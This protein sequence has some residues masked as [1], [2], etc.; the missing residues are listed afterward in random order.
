MNTD[1]RKGSISDDSPEI[2]PCMLAN[3]LRSLAMIR[4]LH[5]VL[6]T[7]LFLLLLVAFAFSS[8]IQS[9]RAAGSPL[10]TLRAGEPSPMPLATAD[11]QANSPA[12]SEKAR[13]ALAPL[14][15]NAGGAL[16]TC[17]V[18][19]TAGW[20]ATPFILQ[21]GETVRVQYNYGGWTV[22]ALS[23]PQVGAEGYAPEIDSTIAP[24]C[25]VD[26]G[27]P[28][29]KLLGQI[30]NGPLIPIGGTLNDITANSSGALN[31]RINDQDGCLSDND[32]W[33]I[34]SILYEGGFSCANVTEIPVSECEGLVDL[35]NST[36]G[37][38]WTNRS[39]W[40][41]T[42]TLCSWFG[43]S[44]YNNHLY[45]VNLPNNNLVGTL[46]I[47]INKLGFVDGLYLNDNHL[48]GSI[49][50]PIGQLTLL[51]LD[52]SN[53]QLGGAIPPELGSIAGINHLFLD[54][55]QFTG[56]IPPELG[57]FNRIISLHLSANYLSGPIPTQLGNLT[58]LVNLGLCCN[59]LSGQIPA[60]LGN[61][62][63]L[64]FLA[65]DSNQFTGSLPS[66]LGNL[67]D[68]IE[69]HL[70]N[71]GSVNGPLP[72][73][74]TNL[75]NLANFGFFN[76]GLCEPGDSTFQNWLA[77]IANLQRTNI[78]C[79][80]L[81]VSF[82]APTFRV[83]ENG[84]IEGSH[85]VRLS[86]SSSQPV[87]VQLNTSNGS[88]TTGSD[89]V[90]TSI[91]FTFSP[92]ESSKSFVIP[93]LQDALDEDDEAINLTLSNPTNATLGTPANA[94]LII[95]DD[96]PLPTVQFSAPTYSINES[97]GGATIWAN[98]SP[99]SGRRVTVN[100]AT[101]DGTAI[102]GS[103]YQ[104]KSGTLIFNAG[105][106]SRPF[107]VPILDD[108][109]AEEAESV[110][111]TLSGASSSANLGALTSAILT[112]ADNDQSPC[113]TLATTVSP[114]NA[115][116]I[117]VSPA[118]DCQGGQYTQGTVVSLS[119][120]AS[121][122]FEFGVWSGAAN[123]P[124]NP[125]S[126][127]MLDNKQVTANFNP[128]PNTPPV[129][130]NQSVSTAQG[131]PV[132]IRLTASDAENDP[133]SFVILTGPAHGAFLGTAPSL[134]YQPAPGFSGGDS[135]TFK[136][137]DGKADSNIATVTINVSPRVCYSLTTTVNSGDRGTVAVTPDPNCQG[138]KYTL[139]STVSL[140][141]MATTN[142]SFERWSGSVN[143]SSNPLSIVMD[144]D[145]AVTAT[146]APTT[147]S[148]SNMTEIP[149]SE[150][151]ALVQL[152][153][154]TNGVAW[155]NH[156]G[157]LA[158]LTPCSW[159]GVTCANQHV[160]ALN[161]DDNQLAGSVPAQI[162]NLPYLV[163]LDLNSNQIGGAIPPEITFLA[164][165]Q[166]LD[167]SINYL[168]GAIPSQIGALTSLTHLY[169]GENE[170]TGNAPAQL[171]SLSNLVELG[172][173]TNQL[174]GSI[175]T[176]IGNLTRLTSLS[177][178]DNQFTGKLPDSLANLTNLIYLYLS[179]NEFSG[180]LPANLPNLTKLTTFW[181]Q[182]TH[183][184]EPPNAAFQ[185]WLNS[186][187]FNNRTNIQCVVA[188]FSASPLIEEGSLRDIP[189]L[190]IKVF[191]HS[192]G[193]Y[194][195]C[196]WDFGD[197]TTRDGC[198]LTL[199]I[200]I[201]RE[202]GSYNMSLTASGP[203]GTDTKTRPDYITV[204]KPDEIT[205]RVID[206][207]GAPISG[208]TITMD[209]KTTATTNSDGY[210]TLKGIFAG[211]YTLTPS[212][213]ENTFS[214]ASHTISVTGSSAG[215]DFKINCETSPTTGLNSCKL[216]AG[217]ILLVRGTGEGLFGEATTYLIK[218]GSYFHHAAIYVG[219]QEVTEATGLT[220]YIKKMK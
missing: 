188:D 90:A 37:P 122:G 68:L 89:F 121:P 96:D 175:P 117:N 66:Q 115:G 177:L 136:V 64:K 209:T 194:D 6:P 215:H 101:S 187:Q 143:S 164:R 45:L 107:T 1:S 186:I 30:G 137:N 132:N 29:G 36:N 217:D 157:W 42:L 212:Q 40:L 211:T 184:C 196:I 8:H 114:N 200:H 213:G 102:A 192:M 123:G 145:K 126:I 118:P 82:S 112:I 28:Y 105:D 84:Q 153:I 193:S 160:S 47:Q 133:L 55:N 69:L 16:Y 182:N 220:L 147:F 176:E 67:V 35:Y 207:R 163:T 94:Q 189:P 93:I 151:E 154:R 46:P 33:V 99:V 62:T 19:A 53:N 179:Y 80:N 158:T 173:D 131:T 167:L 100:F 15:C 181:F 135:F 92:N 54:S 197:G 183:L 129:A 97:G 152:Y 205:G 39:G 4:R 180:P 170:L 7:L 87:T 27:S 17:Q 141:A 214:P 57:N 148:C 201:Y 61:L 58:S 174:S 128:P 24:G 59:Q 48:T 108:N 103:D 124:A 63:K 127:T 150:C 210:Y 13:A 73:S 49:P 21:A 155:A 65:L 9:L 44:C 130:N 168:N 165:L 12:N 91:I 31:L 43:V 125:I 185:S 149:A 159:F 86:H 208:V 88:A 79:E 85:N 120:I 52:L 161:L 216:E 38:N 3:L 139:G 219:N 78:P 178:E 75:R 218:L 60:F 70:E 41:A 203:G 71:N 202:V 166:T 98:L 146:F 10:H 206:S 50:P 11:G 26:T 77:G 25:K 134:T 106:A 191:N 81:T 138:N 169:L 83:N 199:P 74:L 140:T 2:L 190:Y 109:S 113:F 171:G 32:G 119:A 51:D 162:G 116:T 142:Y 204:L 34:V 76:T 72:G 5:F 20:Q 23:V 198:D 144:G 104:A 195:N 172:L 22:D 156:T 56:N 95:I 111:L 18:L 110:N 14:I